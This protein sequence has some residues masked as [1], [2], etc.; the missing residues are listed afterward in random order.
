MK[1]IIGI[2]IILTLLSLIFFKGL[3]RHEKQECEIWQRQSQGFRSWYSTDWQ[4][5]QC[6]NYNIILK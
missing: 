3:E 4:K 5:E 1:N 2:L 6:L